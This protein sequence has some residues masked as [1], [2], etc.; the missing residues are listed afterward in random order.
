MPIKKALNKI[1]KKRWNFNEKIK[2]G[3]SLKKSEKEFYNKNINIIKRDYS[4]NNL[5]WK[6]K[7]SIK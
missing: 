3:K 5:Y 4:K 1:L 2:N 6:N 7:G